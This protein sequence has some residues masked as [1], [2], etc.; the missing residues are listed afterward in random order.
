MEKNKVI[1]GKINEDYYAYYKGEEL[2][3]IEY[4]EN[5]KK[6]VWNQGE[7]IMMSED[8]LRSTLNKLVE[9]ENGNNRISQKLV[10]R[11]SSRSY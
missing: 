11:S 6:W 7:D 2:G 1:W 10:K 9:L 3:F 4:Y 8:C 5:W